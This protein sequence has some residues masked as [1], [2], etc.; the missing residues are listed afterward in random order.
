VE[1][2]I[3]ETAVRPPRVI[4]TGVFVAAALLAVAVGIRAAV[5]RPPDVRGQT[6]RQAIRDLE[7]A[8][9]RVASAHFPVEEGDDFVEC[10]APSATAGVVIGQRPCPGLFS[11]A[12]EGSRVTVWIKVPESECVPPPGSV[13]VDEGS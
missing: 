7:D 12:P 9:Y 8:G 13:C 1:E 5:P 11:S 10:Y 4:R 2:Q 6:E 3:P